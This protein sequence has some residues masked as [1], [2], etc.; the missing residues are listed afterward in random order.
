[1]KSKLARIIVGRTA[2]KTCETVPV[3]A[4][5]W[6]CGV[7]GDISPA[8]AVPLPSDTLQVFQASVDIPDSQEPN[9]VGLQVPA[10]SPPAT[11]NVA[12]VFTDS[13]CTQNCLPS[14]YSDV[15]WS[16]ND[17]SVVSMASDSE[18]AAAPFPPDITQIFY[19]A[20][21]GSP[22][23]ISFFF[24]YPANSAAIVA[25]SD[26]DAVP[27]PV[28]GAGLPGMMLASGGLLG[29]WRRRR[30]AGSASLAAT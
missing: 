15:V 3:F 6:C 22:Q 2:A 26:V 7:V 20:E 10:T 14:D 25:R 5:L 9:A 27:G 13:G 29:W 19:S 30:K 1:M 8:S 4:A 28:A 17:G 23:D 12:V 21:T 24:G 18:A 11:P 16:S